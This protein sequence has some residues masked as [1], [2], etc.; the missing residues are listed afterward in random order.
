MSSN[1]VSGCWF[2]PISVLES[3][4]TYYK[5][6]EFHK[7]ICMVITAMCSH[8]LVS[9]FL[10]AISINSATNVFSEYENN[11]ILHKM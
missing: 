3:K 5:V 8:L 6:I 4:F 2:V 11:S 7:F 9:Q 1:E 10:P